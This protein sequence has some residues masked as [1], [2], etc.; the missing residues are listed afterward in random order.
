MAH[1]AHYREAH[2][3]PFVIT[4]YVNLISMIVLIISGILIHFPF[5]A[6]TMGAARGVHIFCGIVLFVNCLLRV[7]LSFVLKSAPAN[8]TRQT[9]TDVKSFLPQADNKHQLGAWLKFYLFAKKDHPLAG[10]YNPMQKIAYIA[11]PFLI[12]F[13]F[14]TGLCLWGATQSW[15]I[16]Q[17]FIGAVGGLMTVRV[18]HYVMMFIF[19]IFMII[20][21]YMAVT[22]GGSAMLKNMFAWK[23]HGG[24]TY[25]ITTHDLSG[26][27]RS[28]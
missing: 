17:A 5:L 2:P 11:V 18:I 24:L 15:G 19:I 6:G 1:L 12:L 28:V 7:I 8:G 26:E 10:K 3:L 16:C 21:V 27:D 22:E 14:Y 23:E 25:D 13:M 4:H 9:T 20:H